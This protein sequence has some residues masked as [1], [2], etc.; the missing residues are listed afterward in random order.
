MSS[1][2][3][4]PHHV[5]RT[6][7]RPDAKEPSAKPKKPHRALTAFL[8]FTLKLAVVAGLIWALLTYV[9]GIYVIHTNDMFPAVR[10]GDLLITYRIG[11]RLRGD[12]IS[13]TVDGQRRFGRVVAI[14]GDVVEMNGDGTYMIGGVIPYESIY[15]ETRPE[16]E[17]G[18]EYPYTVPD[19]C[20][21]VLNDLRDNTGDSRRFGA[22]P[23]TDTDGSAVLLLRRRTW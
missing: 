22:I 19:G 20:V 6:P 12:V 14:A 13:Y 10:D 8:R 16:P 7:S 4:V 15:Y 2:D 23:L 1:K 9:F 3:Y 17:S 11:D 21:F 18:L 5:K